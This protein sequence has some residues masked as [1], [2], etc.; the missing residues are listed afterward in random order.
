[1]DG[2]LKIEDMDLVKR[3]QD[4][5]TEARDHITK[6]RIEAEEDYNFRAGHQWS[7][8]DL[9]KLKDENRPAITF[10]RVDTNISAVIGIEA[11]QRNEVAYLGREHMDD[12]LSEAIEYVSKW[13]NQYADI[14]YEEAMAFEDILSTGMGWT[15]SFMQ[16]E[17]DLDGK[18]IKERVNPLEMLWDIRSEKRNLTDATWVAR[19]KKMTPD[20]VKTI[21]PDADISYE[22]PASSNNQTQTIVNPRKYYTE[23]S[24]E[25][26][27]KKKQ[28][29]VIQY[30]WF[31]TEAIY[32]A[33]EPNTG[34][35]IELSPKDF[36]ANQDILMQGGAKFIK[37]KRRIYYQ[38]FICGNTL[39]EKQKSPS[40]TGFTFKCIT[41]KRD[42]IGK[43]WYGLIRL[44]KDP[45]RWAN[46]FFSMFLDIINSNAKGGIMAES[47][48]FINPKEAEAKWARCDS[49]IY[50]KQGAVSGGRITSK[51]VAPYPQGVER[52][53]SFAIS[54]I[55]EVSGINLELL[56]M[57]D[58]EQAGIVEETRKKSAYAILAPYFDSLKAYRK[59]SGLLLL[60]FIKEYMPINRIAR[61]LPQDYAPLAGQIKNIDLQS[62]D[63][64]VSEA[65]QSEN[66]KLMVWG[67]LSQLLPTLAQMQIPIPS[68]IIEY[69][70]LP[71]NLS[72]K[73]AQEIEKNKQNPQAQ[74][75]Q[76]LAMKEK[77][78]QIEKMIAEAGLANAK[79]ASTDPQ[80]Q[81]QT[82]N[83]DMAMKTNEHQM[84][85]Q[86]HQMNMQGKILDIQGKTHLAN[87]KLRNEM[88]KPQIA[89]QNKL[90]TDNQKGE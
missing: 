25:L 80:A 42:H 59:Q 34:K 46:K 53:L 60:E 62:I 11:N 78:A 64:V 76:M 36:K 41:G 45:Q 56:G 33:Q 7:D 70:P 49:I 71:A 12:S 54:A 67:F 6:W 20:E 37:Q 57:A 65:P 79:A 9:T 38:A 18:Y 47:D 30:Q 85:Q 31:E 68:E 43:S 32:R 88:M 40:Q 73:W 81:T 19:E 21:W 55:R 27:L 39:L 74:Q 10:N 83:I 14:E 8:D 90:Q 72:K 52:L 24:V 15:E 86:E 77:M 50:V 13:V 44:M 2:T 82:Q 4:D 84:K 63:I 58:R 22:E 48:V 61:I 3:I 87:V 69:S 23:G 35:I 5:S 66:N 1:M 16:Y 26:P 89:I 28:L 29:T 17:I 51:P 75:M